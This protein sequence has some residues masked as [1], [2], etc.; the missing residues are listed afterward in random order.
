MYR[1]S[2]LSSQRCSLRRTTP[3]GRMCLRRRSRL[4][5]PKDAGRSEVVAPEDEAG[6]PEA[7]GPANGRKKN[8]PCRVCCGGMGEKGRDK[9]GQRVSIERGI[10][11]KNNQT[12]ELTFNT[13]GLGYGPR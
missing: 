3:D 12:A 10:V 4:V 1:T 5:A 13:R 7:D 11:T 8:S 9:H 6:R 2:I